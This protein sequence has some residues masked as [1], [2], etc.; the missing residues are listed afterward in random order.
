MLRTFQG[1]FS[2]ELHISTWVTKSCQIVL[3]LGNTHYW[4]NSEGEDWG[5]SCL[6]FLSLYIFPC[7]F[8]N[9]SGFTSSVLVFRIFLKNFA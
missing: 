9:P 7:I 5:F 6:S 4:R 3:C 2:T 8:S 1:N